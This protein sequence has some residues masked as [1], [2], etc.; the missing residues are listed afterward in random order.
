MCAMLATGAAPVPAD[1][2]A[3]AP[4]VVKPDVSLLVI[5][6]VKVDEDRLYRVQ[7]TGFRNGKPLP[8]ETI[9]VGE[10]SFVISYWGVKIVNDRYLVTGSGGVLDVREKKVLNTECDGQW[11]IID[12]TKVTYWIESDRREQ[13]KFTFEYATGTLTRID[14]APKA[15]HHNLQSSKVLSPDQRKAVRWENS[16]EL[17]LYREGE[18]PKSLGKV[19][20]ME[21]DPKVVFSRSL[22]LMYF[23]VLWLDNE[24]LLTQRD[25]GKLVT[26]D[27]A[28]TVTDI[29]TIKDMPKLASFSLGRDRSG[30]IFYSANGE[31]YAIDLAKKTAVR[32]KWQSLGHGFEAS[33][34]RDEKLY[35]KLRY[36]GKDIGRLQCSPYTAKTAPGYLALR[37]YVGDSLSSAPG[38]VAVWS[39]ATGE[40]AQFDYEMLSLIPVVGWIK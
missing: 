40:W 23:P 28:G 10:E 11:G 6:S 39:V 38:R 1:K 9:W 32:S 36:N 17:I 18:K 37:A 25:H 21:E 7:R 20:K 29:V 27:L 12:E 30:T 15:W 34:E 13:G 26:V 14:K 33:W 3:P 8:S 22:D 4:R 2:V 5:D 35:H 24:T 19:F 16:N 31:K